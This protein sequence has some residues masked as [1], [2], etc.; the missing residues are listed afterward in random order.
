MATIRAVVFDMDGLMVDSEPHWQASETA[1]FKKLGVELT[2]TDWEG[3]MGLRLDEV[4][5]HYRAHRP[6]PG[7]ETDLEVQQMILDEMQAAL[8]RDP[9][10]MPGL[11]EALGA[12]EARDLPLAVASSS[13]LVL[14]RAA[15]EGLGIA[16]RFHHLCSA[17]KE[18]HGKPHPAVYMRAA[19]ALGVPCTACLAFEDSLN[20]AISAKA[21]R[22]RCAAVPDGRYAPDK[23]RFAFADAVLGSLAE[24]AEEGFWERVAPPRAQPAP[25]AAPAADV[26]RPQ[27]KAKAG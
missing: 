12:C 21:A 10:P 13:P 26:A 2:K 8:R 18:A 5:K 19:E 27:K 16:G 17:E 9:R 25:E 24:V 7:P 22:M 4:V 1:V 23:K 3:T 14:I 20:G 15:L 11:H 6:W